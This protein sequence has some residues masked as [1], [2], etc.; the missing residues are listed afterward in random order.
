MFKR[1]NVTTRAQPYFRYP[2]FGTGS[3]ASAR[4]NIA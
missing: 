3:K 1:V 4:V 2:G